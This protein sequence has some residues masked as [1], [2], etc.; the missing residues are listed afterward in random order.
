MEPLQLQWYDYVL[1]IGLF[2]GVSA[3]GLY[4]TRGASEEDYLVG[5]RRV[6]WL[7]LSLSIAAE[8]LGGGVMLVFSRFAYSFG[9]S[10]LCIIGGIV[11]GTFLLIPIALRYKNL[12]DTQGFY[13][14]PDLFRYKWGKFAGWTSTC[15]VAIW[16]LGFIAMQLVAAGKLLNFMIGSNYLIGVTAAAAIVASYLII[17]GFRSVIVTDCLQYVALAVVLFI[18]LP[19]SFMKIDWG[20]TLAHAG[21]MDPAEALGF[22]ILGGL[23]MVVSADLWQRIYAAR[24]A[25]DARRGVLIGAL[26]ILAGGLLLMIPALA[27]T[28][29]LDNTADT[30]SALFVA[31]RA[32]SP[33]LIL[34]LA[35]AAV[36]MSVM[37]T[38]DTMVFVLGLAISHDFLVESLGKSVRFRKQS[39]QI[40]MVL[41]L[42]AGAFVAIINEH[43]QDALLD[44]GLA[45]TSFALILAPPIVISRKAKGLSSKAVN[46]SLS[47]GIVVGGFLMIGETL[48]LD[49]LTPENSVLVLGGSILGAILGGI[50]NRWW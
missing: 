2:A 26:L 43:N 44:I 19:A 32:Y 22:L 25:N 31:L 18:A 24:S 3:I 9:L 39:A 50:M 12:A 27:S 36:L 49:Q 30:R 4:V 37:S 17:G 41:A 15:V 29:L 21:Q 40:A 20:S 16:T 5:G 33:R 47:L 1:S 14:L 7:Q 45:V 13:S 34:G 6:S 11:I 48:G 23:N 28:G 46:W 8:V 42:L 38:L 35:M 10:S